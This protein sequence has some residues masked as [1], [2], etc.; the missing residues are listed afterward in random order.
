MVSS[1]PYITFRLRFRLR[2]DYARK[3]K[4]SNYYRTFTSI[5]NHIQKNITIDPD[6]VK[7]VQGK[8][9]LQ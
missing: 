5:D 6:F 4:F 7:K 9:Y 8:F 2:L 3:I 1:S